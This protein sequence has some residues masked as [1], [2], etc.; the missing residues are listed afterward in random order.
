MFGLYVSNSHSRLPMATSKKAVYAAIAGNF[1]IAITKFV[2]AA[3]SGSSA[4]MAE[5]IHSLVDTGNGGLLLLGIRRSRRPPDRAH[6]FGYGKELYFYTLIVAILIFSVG[7]GI[8]IY[9]GVHHTLH[10]P[11]A[12]GD[13]LLNYV[14]LGLAMMF[15]GFAWRT[16]YRAFRTEHPDRPFW[17]AVRGAKDPTTFAVLFE[18]SAAMAGLVLAAV[19]I[20]LGQ[21]LE[22][23]VMDGLASVS[24][25]LVLCGVSGMLIY[26]SKGLLLGESADPEVVASIESIAASVDGIRGIGRILT[27]H[28]GANRVILNLDVDFRSSLSSDEV[29]RAVGALERA[30]REKHPRMQ[31]I[32]VEAT[33]I[34]EAAERSADEEARSASP[35]TDPDDPKP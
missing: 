16:A 15:E 22:M 17:T 19:G 2:A 6:P 12:L 27:M 11:D 26:E 28:V 7:G 31:Y 3:V 10:P 18:D 30:V 23:P 13:P 33:S 32:F 29:E 24:I 1:A 20:F 35:E 9:E 5:G 25:G 8:S 14:V 21:Q 4:M 34:A